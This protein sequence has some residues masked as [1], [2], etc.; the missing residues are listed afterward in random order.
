MIVNITFDS[1]GSDSIVYNAINE[2]I[3]SVMKKL[4]FSIPW[5]IESVTVEKYSEK[6]VFF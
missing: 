6:T 2:T 4:K 3:I 1:N 5:T